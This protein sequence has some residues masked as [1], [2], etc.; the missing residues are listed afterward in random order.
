MK[1]KRPKPVTCPICGKKL[2]SGVPIVCKEVKTNE[3]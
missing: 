3:R 2:K 1:K